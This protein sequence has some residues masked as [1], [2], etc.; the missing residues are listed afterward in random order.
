MTTYRSSGDVGR[1]ALVPFSP[2]QRSSQARVTQRGERYSRQPN[3]VAEDT[4]NLISSLVGIG[5]AELV[6]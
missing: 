2:R 4:H 6:Q 3:F 5:K 1:C